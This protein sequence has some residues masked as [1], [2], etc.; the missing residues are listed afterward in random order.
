[1]GNGSYPTSV[2]S[3]RQGRMARAASVQSPQPPAWYGFPTQSSSWWQVRGVGCVRVWASGE[4]K[5]A[6]ACPGEEGE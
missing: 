3:W 4:K 1:M 2:Q 6:S 5:S